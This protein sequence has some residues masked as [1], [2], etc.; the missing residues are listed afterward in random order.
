LGI[1]DTSSAEKQYLAKSLKQVEISDSASK[2]TAGIPLASNKVTKLVEILVRE[3]SPE[4]SR[5]VFVQE[6]PTREI[7]A[8]LLSIHPAMGGL[9]RVGMIVGTSAYSLR[10]GNVAELVEL[11]AQKHVL[12]RFR[13]GA[14]NL[15]VPTTVL[16]E[17]IDVTA[18]N[19]VVCFVKPANLKSFVQRRGR[20]RQRN[21][22]VILLLDSMVDKLGEYEQLEHDMRRIYED[23]M[24]K[25]QEILVIED[26]EEHDGRYF[27]IGSAGALLDLD[28]TLPHLY[29]FCATLPAKEYVDVRP[30]VICSEVGAGLRARVILPLSGHTAVRTAESQMLWLSERNAIKDAAFEAFVALYKAGL[31]NDNLLPLL[32]NYE[33]ADEFTSSTVEKGASIMTVNETMN[34]WADISKAWKTCEAPDFQVST[35]TV[36]ELDIEI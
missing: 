27:R 28:N 32:R 30:E 29:H 1:W 13:S 20:A 24:R 19:V 36:S 35:I 16:E 14:I 8:R 12:S 21:S 9:F 33:V 15:V 10:A 18:C 17:G 23:E 5:I 2:V 22:K 6:R 26:G 25:L 4:F 31:I 34:P 11:D 3:A 7:L